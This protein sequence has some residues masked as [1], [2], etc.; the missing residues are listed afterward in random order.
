MPMTYRSSASVALLLCSQLAAG[1]AFA[2]AAD[3]PLT[4]PGYIAGTMKADFQTQRPENQDGDYPSKGVADRFTFDLAVG[5]SKYRGTVSCLPHIFSKH[6]GRVIQD[7]SCTYDLSLAVVNPQNTSQVKDIGKLVGSYAMDDKGQVNLS[8][9]NLRMEVQTMGKAQGFT[10]AFT[11]SFAG[12]PPRKVTTLGQLAD[13]AKRQARTIEKMVD[14]KKVSVALGD[15]DPLR[16]RSTVLAMG[17]VA[18]Y[19]EATVDGELIYS[20]E[21]DNWFPQLTMRV[22]NAKPDTVG[23]GMRWVDDSPTEGH[24]ELNVIFNESLE[25]GETAAFSDAQGEDAFFLTDSTQ[26][27]IN[28]RIDFRDQK[29]DDAVVHSDVRFDIGLQNVTAIQ[30][31]NFAKLLMLLPVQLWGE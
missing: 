14:G 7:G 12:K 28:G 11:G 30:A 27:V 16:F 8:A 1:G 22:G 15:V 10:S 2:A 13:E 3:E 29:V 20:Y 4:Q 24:Y 6:I 9:G 31:Q 26:S 18:T 25:Q 19:P 23:G 21:T 17:P 5:F